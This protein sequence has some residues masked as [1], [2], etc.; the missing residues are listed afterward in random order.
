MYEA[1]LKVAIAAA[2]AAGDAVR[3]L[4]ERAA[5]AAYTKGDGSPVTDADLAADRIIREHLEKAFPDDAILT[6]EGA[7]DQARLGA[8]RIWIVDPI[9]G[10]Q[11]FIDRSG[12]FDVLIALAV[13]GVPVVGVMLQPTTGWYL[14]ARQG[15]GAWTGQGAEHEPFALSPAPSDRPPRISTSI[16]LNMPHGLAGVQAAARRL[17]A[18]EPEVSVFGVIA[19]HFAMPERR[20]DTLIGLPTRVDQTMAWEWDF[21]TADVIVREAGGAFTDAWG[22]PFRYN[23]P[24][25]RNE[26]GIVLSVD[27]RTHE[28]V[29]A[30]IEPELPRE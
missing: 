10:T 8:E 21:A 25:P 1:E 12:E 23:K 6:E 14:A 16:W 29:L 4:Y 11:Q 13:N 27:P 19:R 17:G 7:D 3:D 30:A 20:H 18:E 2:Q 26:G 5:A 9:D 28:R 22:R 24:L 15:A